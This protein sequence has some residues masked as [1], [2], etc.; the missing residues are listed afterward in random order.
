MK[1]VIEG[2]KFA[3]SFCVNN[4]MLLINYKSIM[5]EHEEVKSNSNLIT[6]ECQ[7]GSLFNC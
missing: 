7:N 2:L 3:Q 4:A 1:G 6:I 5:V